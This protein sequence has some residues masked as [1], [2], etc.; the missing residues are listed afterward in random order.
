[1]YLIDDAGRGAHRRRPR[2][3]KVF[4]QC[5]T[6]VAQVLELVGT[7]DGYP[8][9]IKARAVIARRSAPGRL[10]ARTVGFFSRR[11][12]RAGA[13]EFKM[14]KLSAAEYDE[15]TWSASTWL[16]FAMQRISVDTLFG[17]PLCKII[18]P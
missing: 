8:L 7:E 14:N 5:I 18:G 9:R 17:Q 2:G 12:G 11:A 4:V 3:K 6:G 16:T 1:M 13:A 10:A 15:T